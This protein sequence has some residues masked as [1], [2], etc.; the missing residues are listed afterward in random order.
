MNT[1]GSPRP[2]G[3]SGDRQRPSGLSRLMMIS[4]GS[5]NSASF[6]FRGPLSLNHDSEQPASRGRC[7]AAGFNT[8]REWPAALSEKRHGAS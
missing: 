1:K 2:L 5:T 6:A 8:M 7:W 4:L 3:V